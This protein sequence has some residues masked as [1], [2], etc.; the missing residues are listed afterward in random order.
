MNAGDLW[1]NLK[2]ISGEY[3]NWKFKQDTLRKK[4]RKEIPFKE[5]HFH[6]LNYWRDERLLI[7]YRI[8]GYYKDDKLEFVVRSSVLQYEIDGSNN[9]EEA[10]NTIRALV[11]SLIDE[12]GFSLIIVEEDNDTV[13]DFTPTFLFD[14]DLDYYV[15]GVEGK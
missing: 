7:D 2:E 10:Y 15:Y 9:V 11:E 14:Q 12:G 8:L 3:K 5:G 13:Y 4:V 1:N 6:V